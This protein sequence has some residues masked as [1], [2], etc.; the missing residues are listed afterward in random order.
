MPIGTRDVAE[1][2]QSSQRETRSEAGAVDTGVGRDR[3][4]ILLIATGY[5]A[6]VVVLVWGL[7][8]GELLV[9]LLGL[10][11]VGLALI[12]RRAA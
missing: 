5:T 10:A 6:G 4:T 9:I 1:S 7:L 8:S 3:W 2:G 12:T 11:I